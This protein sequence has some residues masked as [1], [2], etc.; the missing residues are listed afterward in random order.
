MNIDQLADQWQQY[1]IIEQTAAANRKA[2]EQQMQELIDIKLEG[3][4]TEETDH[5]EIKVVGKVTRSLD[6]DL[7]QEDWQNLP[8]AVQDC[9]KWKPQVDTKSL[10]ALEAIDDM[11]LARYMTTKPAKPSF[12]IKPRGE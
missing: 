12:S 6:A 8:K 5:F 9:V 3:S 2:I 7:L 4:T 11:T 1:K 10:R